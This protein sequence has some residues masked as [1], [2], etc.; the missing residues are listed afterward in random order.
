[1]YDKRGRLFLSHEAAIFE[2]SLL[3]ITTMDSTRPIALSCA[4][5]AVEQFGSFSHL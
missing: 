4:I 3:P 1:M 5:T 2:I